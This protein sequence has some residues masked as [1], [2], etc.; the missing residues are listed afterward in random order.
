MRELKRA[1]QLV[2]GGWNE[3]FCLGRGIG[4][5]DLDLRPENP[6]HP[7]LSHQTDK[8]VVNWD[9]E[10]V[11]TFSVAG[12]LQAAGAWPEGWDLLESVISPAT[13]ALRDFL[14]SVKKGELSKEQARHIVQL[15]KAGVGEPHLQQ[16]LQE[17]GRTL[18]QVL[19]IF[20]TAILRLGRGA[21]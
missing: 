4:L 3:P 7:F 8:L 12:A 1:R 2:A 5:W 15:C 20:N 10:S 16:W 9:D 17:Q 18:D 14:Q 6:T 13:C 11:H 19:K 21:H